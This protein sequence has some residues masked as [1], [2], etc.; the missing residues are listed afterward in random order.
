MTFDFWQGMQAVDQAFTSAAIVSHKYLDLTILTVVFLDGWERL[1]TK[2]KTAL[3]SEGG[4]QGLGVPVLV[5]QMIFGPSGISTSS[6][7][8]LE[9]GGRGGVVTFVVLWRGLTSRGRRL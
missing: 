5:S 6:R 7:M 8:I 9:C 3:R 4:T 2:S 1:C